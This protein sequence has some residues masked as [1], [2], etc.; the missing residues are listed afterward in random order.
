M[1]EREAEVERLM[2]VIDR[3]RYVV[4]HCVG[5]ITDA[6]HGRTW[7]LEGRGPYEWDDDRYREEFGDALKAIEEAVQP[8][9]IV[10]WDKSDCTR[11]EARV[12]AAKLAARKLLEKPHGPRDM[13]AADLFGDPR[14]AEIA[15]LR[16][17]L[18]PTHP[19]GEPEGWRETLGKRDLTWVIGEARKSLRL[20]QGCLECN[21]DDERRWA[22]TIEWLERLA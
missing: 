17:V 14:D 3:D 21:A 18:H 12:N 7:V 11:I 20:V 8:L 6:I 4:A 19:V 16:A 5:A 15:R 9:R 10:A 22:E 13:I 1:V 2:H